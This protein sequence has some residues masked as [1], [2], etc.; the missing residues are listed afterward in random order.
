MLFVIYIQFK[1]NYANHLRI[2]CIKHPNKS[3]FF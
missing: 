1:V 2:L 3:T